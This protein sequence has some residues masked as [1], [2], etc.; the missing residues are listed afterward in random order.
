MS[1]YF[2]NTSSKFVQASTWTWKNELIRFW[3]SKVTML[4]SLQEHLEGISL[5]LAQ[6]Q[7]ES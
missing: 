4:L 1:K 3:R 5:H 2:R 6:T 7:Q